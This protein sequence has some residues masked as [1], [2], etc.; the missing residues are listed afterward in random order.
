MTFRDNLSIGPNSRASSPKP[1]PWT[2]EPF[3]ETSVTNNQPTPRYIPQQRGP[4]LQPRDL[5]K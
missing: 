4:D 3:S 1:G 5:E 2:W